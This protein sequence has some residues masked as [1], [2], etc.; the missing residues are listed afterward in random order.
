MLKFFR[1]IRKKLIEKDNVRKYLLYAIGEIL[2]VVIG[3]LIALQ[4]NNWNEQRKN[5][6]KVENYTHSLIADLAK[7]SVAIADILENVEKETLLFN[8]F[9]QRL[10]SSTATVDTVYQIFQNEFIFLTHRIAAFN[11]NTFNV[12]TTTG[13]IG[14]FPDSL[15]DR[16]FSLSSAHKD[17][18][19]SS[20]HSWENF[21]R[22]AT[23]F[24]QKFPL[25]LSFS[26]INSGSL[27]DNLLKDD[28]SAFIAG[29]NAIAL[30]KQ[31]VY[32]QTVDNLT[33]VQDQTHQLLKVLR[34]S[35]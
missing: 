32:R 9:Q 20:S 22:A 1:T 17:A 19:A 10:T 15:S 25:P 29:F 33:V 3:I 35:K 16:L 18:L 27:Y 24:T 12:L 8:N 7:D 14:L 28:Q 5:Q 23:N 4:V 21:R 11:N 34:E 13:D 2:L 26:I 6:I 30:A 31:N